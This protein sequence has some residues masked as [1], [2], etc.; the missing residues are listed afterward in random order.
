[1][2]KIAKNIGKPALATFLA[3]M[4]LMSAAC[5]TGGKDTAEPSAEAAQ[6]SQA[7]AE[8]QGEEATGEEAA[9]DGQEAPAEASEKTS[10][11]NVTIKVGVSPSPH[12]VIL[13]SIV[14][15]L[16]ERGIK[17]EIVTFTDYVQPNMALE[18]GSL[19]ANYFQH[20]PYLLDFNEKNGTH[21]ASIA[22]IHYEPMALYKGK[23]ENLDQLADG[24][25][26]A[27]PNDGT[28]E[29]RALQ[30]LAANGII[31][32]KDGAGLAAT[33]N[34]ILE[35]P[36]NVD[37]VEIEAAQVPLSLPDVDFGVVNGNYAI[38]A[39]LSANEDAVLVESSDETGVARQ[40]PNVIAVREGDETRP[41][42]LAFLEELTSPE[43][44]AFIEETYQG[45]VVPLF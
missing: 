37:I 2:K 3:A 38:N 15:R 14:P 11:D 44:K 22:E 18:D 7:P 28:N 21:L 12:A 31:T 33:K 35:N 34:D 30:L 5:G 29:A 36:K 45:V 19:D 24:S 17:L 10:F 13:E 16:A 42:L 4:M 23:L 9:A 25:K 41:E 26:I 8:A 1:M 43:T 6:E 40:F 39:G 32:L 27:V 20:L